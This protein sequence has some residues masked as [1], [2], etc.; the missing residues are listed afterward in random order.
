[1]QELE[2]A[3]SALFLRIGAIALF[4]AFRLR[5]TLKIRDLRGLSAV[6]TQPPHIIQQ[7]LSLENLALPRNRD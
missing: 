2:I 5:S 7:W 4:V 3:S 1:M 6:E